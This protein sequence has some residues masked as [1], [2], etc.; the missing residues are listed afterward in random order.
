MTHFRVWAP[1]AKSVELRLDHVTHRM[2]ADTSGW[3]S[4][5]C[6]APADAAHQDA[7]YQ[8]MIDGAG[9]WPDPRSAWQR[10]GVHGASRTVDPWFPWTDAHWQAP[11]LSSAVIYELHIGTF[12]L[13]GT[14]D[15]ALA[16]LDYL[17][18][19]GVTHVELM[20]VNQFSGRW[21]W[22]YDGVDLYA[23]HCAYG[24]PQ[25]LKRLVDAC[26]SRGLAVILDVV[27]NHLGPVGNYLGKFGPYFTDRYST[28][29]GEAIN[30]D[31][32]GSA[33]VRRFLCD[34]ALM[35]L[36]EYHFDGLRL[37]A[38]HAIFDSSAVHFLEQLAAEVDQLEA[39]TGRH[40]VVIAESDLNDPRVITP[41]EAG[42]FGVDAQ[43]SDDFHHAL[44]T[45]LTGEKTGYYADFGAMADLA[46]ALQNA[47]VYDGRFSKFRNRV[48][49]RKPDRLAGSRF[50]GY[51]QTHDQVGNRATGDRIAQ[52]AGVDLAKT[53]A[54][55]VMC[56][57]F[58][59]M[60]FQGEEFAAGAPFL[61]FS[62]H[63]DPEVAAAVSA[64]RRREFAAF[65]WNPEHVPDPQDPKTFERSKLDWAEVERE[66]HRE[67]LEWY[68]RLIALRRSVP[69]L[70][71][72][73][74]DRV[75]VD[76]SEAERWLVLRR[77]RVSAACNFSNLVRSIRA[78]A[79]RV[80]LSSNLDSRVQE[81]TILLA[82]FSAMIL[83]A[84]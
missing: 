54:A 23:P 80:L 12:T 65:G 44:H 68:R 67:V 29:W 56:S 84:D 21:G 60:L 17:A 62:D 36:R 39:Q 2:Q 79:Q 20:P 63:Q 14:F 49:G 40:L 64:G 10:D 48:H 55:L 58:V 53:A 70:S 52:I 82:P 42:G 4:V 46:K 72:A 57:P 32:A 50:L 24:C 1:S 77:G 15:A 71:N 6:E 16:K 74:L 25:A 13:E 83:E 28:P 8:Y 75:E 3:W 38:I 47:F 22:G 78:S 45:V 37:D 26:H 27:Y 31:G 66:P 81:E 18:Q 9:P 30:M 69:E 7:A 59:P 43:W 41:R 11:P 73:N 5:A 51:I 35:W 34:N 33:E 61:Y 19:L 76:F